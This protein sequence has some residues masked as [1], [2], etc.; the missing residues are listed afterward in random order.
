[1]DWNTIAQ[2]VMVAGSAGFFIMKRD[3]RLSVI[4]EKLKWQDERFQKLEETLEK[5]DDKI[6]KLKDNFFLNNKKKGD[7]EGIK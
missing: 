4:E 7:L 5:I 3:N 6:D 2:W 1:M